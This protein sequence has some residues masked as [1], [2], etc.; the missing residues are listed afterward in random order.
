[1]STSQ[2][3]RP[4]PPPASISTIQVPPTLSRF[5]IPARQYLSRHNSPWDGVAVGALVFC[6][7]PESTDS[8]LLIQRAAADSLPNKWEIPSGVVSNDP[9]KDAT[10]TNAV[11]RELWEEAGLTATAIKRLVTPPR[12]EEGFV[13]SNSTNTKVFCRFVFE[14]ELEVEKWESVRGRVKLNP[15]EHQRFVWAPEDAVRKMLADK[16]VFHG[17]KEEML[18][19]TSRHLGELILEAFRLRKEDKE[20]R[21]E[22]REKKA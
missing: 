3:P 17:G 1:M 18:E 5:D 22:D 9:A 20:K 21:R 15:V 13:F 6:P 19:L 8:V 2:P 7:S 4:G 14:V 16:A 11:A 12:E 10:I